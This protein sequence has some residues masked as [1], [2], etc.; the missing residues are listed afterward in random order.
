MGVNMKVR[1]NIAA[2]SLSIKV[3]TYLVLLLTGAIL[4]GSFFRLE[5]LWA[6]I[7]LA[8]IVLFCY[9]SAPIAYELNQNQ[10]IVISRT[11]KKVF[12]PILKC[13]FFGED[14]PTFSLRLWGNGGIFTGTG[15]FWN[16]KYGVFRAYV[17]TGDMSKLLLM[18]TPVSKIIITPE[19]PEDFI[20]LANSSK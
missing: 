9:L 6:G 12:G 8:A 18:E 14:K 4:V 5:L 3:V 7:V 19:N 10:L 1:Y 20:V 11:S 2:T 16:K 17:S 13:S 15:I